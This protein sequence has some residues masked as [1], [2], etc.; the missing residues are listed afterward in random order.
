MRMQ[1]AQIRALRIKQ[2]EIDKF[3]KEQEEL[4][5][6]ELLRQEIEKNKS[7]F[8]MSNANNAAPTFQSSPKKVIQPPLIVEENKEY[9]RESINQGGQ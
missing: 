6:K 5:R 4:Q 2:E 8:V 9:Q 7:H 3:R 1:E